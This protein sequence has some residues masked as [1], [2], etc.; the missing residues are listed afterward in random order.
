MQT[1]SAIQDHPCRRGGPYV[2]EIADG[3]NPPMACRVD[4]VDAEICAPGEA[5]DVEVAYFVN[6]PTQ[7]QPFREVA[8]IKLFRRD[9]SFILWWSPQKFLYEMLVRGLRVGVGDDSDPLAFIDFTVLYVG[10]AFDQKV[11]DRLTGHDKMQKI[12]TVQ[13][14]VGAGPAARAPFEVSLILLTVVG[15]TEAVEIPYVG[16]SALPGVA[17]VLHDLDVNDDAALERFMCEQFV[18]LRDEA[19]T[20]EVEA[21][22]IHHFQPAYNE[23]KFK[24]YPKIAGGM[25][26]K[27]YSWT[28]LLI[29]GLPAALSTPYFSVEPVVELKFEEA[30]GD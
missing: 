8:A 1:A 2:F 7:A 19:L 28:D 27:G 11:W 5:I 26:S 16:A 3:V 12:L 23:V 24:N 30:P 20:R 18:P 13:S 15:L 9:G 25:R 21:H 22:L 29:E 17:P 14:P 10:K 6:T 4:L